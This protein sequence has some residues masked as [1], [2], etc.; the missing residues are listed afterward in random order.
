[1]PLSAFIFNFCFRNIF[2][3]KQK[4]G[5]KSEKI[6]P[7]NPFRYVLQS[8]ANLPSTSPQKYIFL[9]NENLLSKASC[10]KSLFSALIRCEIA[11]CEIKHSSAASVKLS[12]RMTVK[13]CFTCLSIISDHFLIYTM[14]LFYHRAGLFYIYI[15]PQIFSFSLPSKTLLLTPLSDYHPLT[16]GFLTGCDTSLMASP[17]ASQPK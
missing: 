4:K 13:K 16:A 6:K 8:P 14:C 9:H 12:T 11:D 1:M 10:S 7:Q 17:K 15:F 3:M 5:S 2:N